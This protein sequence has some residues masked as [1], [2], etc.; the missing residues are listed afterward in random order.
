MSRKTISSPFVEPDNVISPNIRAGE[1]YIGSSQRNKLESF[2]SLVEKAYHFEVNERL[3]GVFTCAEAFKFYRGDRTREAR[4]VAIIETLKC[5]AEPKI[6][7]ELCSQLKTV[8]QYC[9]RLSQRDY[10]Y[11]TILENVIYRCLTD[12]IKDGSQ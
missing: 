1:S 9:S 12:L 2:E 6:R 8:A 5:D 3:D 11:K 4:T 10:F 7:I